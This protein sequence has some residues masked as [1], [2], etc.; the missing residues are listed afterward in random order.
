MP[1]F[2]PRTR[3]TVAAAVLVASVFFAACD[4][5]GGG[6]DESVSADDWVSEFCSV[7]K[8]FDGRSARISSDLQDLDYTREGAKDDLIGGFED[9]RGVLD[10]FQRDTR[11]IG[12]LDIEHGDEVHDALDAVFDDNRGQA[13]DAIAK[14]KDLDEG[15]DFGDAVSDELTGL[16]DPATLR[17]RLEDIGQQDVDDLIAAMD[18]NED[19]SDSSI[20]D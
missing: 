8:R 20:L 5:G 18:A 4:D 2:A 10:D 12:R 1:V 14:V 16:D 17:S 19:C 3:T 6:S 7:S 13:E 9:Y 11:E 15:P